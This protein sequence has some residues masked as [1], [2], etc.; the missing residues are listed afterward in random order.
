MKYIT[1]VILQGNCSRDLL[2]DL[3]K[4]STILETLQDEFNKE[5]GS[6]YRIFTLW[7][8]FDYRRI[9]KVSYI[10]AVSTLNDLTFM[11]VQVV[12][13]NTAIIGIS[14]ETVLGMQG[15]HESMIKFSNKDEPGYKE[16]KNI[17]R[18]IIEDIIPVDG[19]LDSGKRVVSTP[20]HDG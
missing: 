14:N 19:P 1:N 18:R 13:K 5:N 7:E 15:D 3:K 8:L 6:R 12:D 16:V 17:V 4:G 9:G 10:G 11:A 2:R 20:L